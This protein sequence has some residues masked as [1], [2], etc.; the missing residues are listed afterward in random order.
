MET[1]IFRKTIDIILKA[2]TKQVIFSKHFHSP[3]SRARTSK[4]FIVSGGKSLSLNSTIF[5][6]SKPYL[7]G[8]IYY[9]QL[10]QLLI[11]DTL[12]NNPANKIIGIIIIG[13]NSTARVPLL[14][15]LAMR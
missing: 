8:E 2:I 9:S 3:I 15:I 12:E 7:T 1:K 13:A 10:I 14:K 5:K 6:T 11:F 4:G